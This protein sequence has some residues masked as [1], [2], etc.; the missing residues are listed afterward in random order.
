MKKILDLIECKKQAYAELPL[1]TFMQDTQINPKQRLGFAPCMAHFIM[2][3][4]DL[5]KYVFRSENSTNSL[6]Q[7]VNKHTYEDDH[8]Y[9]WF[10]TDLNKLGFNSSQGFVDTLRFLWGENTKITRQLSYQLAAYTL[11]TDPIYKVVVI[12]AVE[13]TGHILFSLTAKVAAELESIHHQE[14]PYFGQFHLKLETGHVTGLIDSEK[15][16]QEI[17]LTEEQ[18]QIAADLVE[19]VFDIFT[20]WADELLTYANQSYTANPT[21]N[22]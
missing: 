4:G 2:S 18:S 15:C 7:L 17:V 12:E 21:L 1:F 9:P 6:Q 20:Q 14:Y 19:K 13:A 3:F 22:Q 11:D 5:N 10:L 16:L 8:H